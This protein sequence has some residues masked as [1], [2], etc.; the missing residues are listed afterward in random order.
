MASTSNIQSASNKSIRPF[1]SG[2]QYLYAMKEDLAEWLKEIYSLE[3]GLDTF[4]EV[5]ETGSVLCQHANNVSKVA[6]QLA[7]QDNPNLLSISVSQARLPRA[8]VTYAPNAQPGTFLARDNVSNFIHWCRKELEIKD[9]LM[10]ETD[11]LVLRKNEKNFVLCL[12]EVARR[13]CAVDTA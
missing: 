3:I 12:L 13:C 11:D 4:M 5:L 6:Q 10:F 7:S 2:E 1:K 9:V 8:Q